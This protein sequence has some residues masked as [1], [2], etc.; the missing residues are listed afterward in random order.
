MRIGTIVC[1]IFSVICM[2]AL[3]AY[4]FPPEGV[5]VGGMGLR[6]PSPAEVLRRGQPGTA[7]ADTVPEDTLTT[8]ELMQMRLDAL[9]AEKE[10]EF[11]TYCETNPA[12]I[13]MPE[14]NTAYLDP[15]FEALEAAGRRTMR[16]LHY[17][18]SQ[19]EGDRITSILREAFQEK[20][21]GNGVGLVPAV[22][23]VP[24]YTLSQSVQPEDLPR[25]LVYGP[26][27]MR[28]DG[29]KDY[30]VMG[31]VAT[32]QDSATFNFSTRSRDIYP[33]ASRFSRVSLLAGDT[34]EA[35][36]TAG[37]DTIYLKENKL[38]DR[39]YLYTCPLGAMHRTACLS[40]HGQAD[41]YGLMLD[42]QNGVAFDNIPMR[43]CSGTIF[44]SVSSSTLAP[45]YSH[46]NVRLIILQY[47]GN[48]VP[49]LKTE[50]NIKH[51]ADELARQV[52]YLKN[53]AP[54]ACFLFIGPSDMSTSIDGTMQT[55]PMLPRVV[56]CL[57]EM[58]GA[59]GIA[60]WDLYAAMGGRGSMLKWVDSDLAG[61][62]YV[63]FTPK[64]ARHVGRV[65]YETLEFYHKFYR[66]RTGKDVVKI[67]EEKDSADT[68]A[69]MDTTATTAA[70][71]DT[72]R[73]S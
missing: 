67:E 46:E 29:T 71:P 23:T 2:L 26:K 35:F 32:I 62:D 4:F 13:Y 21:G 51:Y 5:T 53:L 48:S 64:G 61:P 69:H 17:G 7:L 15:L 14:G 27:D 41:I 24:T 65:L 8:E 47:G 72:P 34:V 44:T 6:F 25:H 68:A 58:A 52:N 28:L 38:S 66:F 31:Q 43:G 60:Y 54:E 49:Y 10:S 18:D 36:I 20:F 1:F 40:V 45:F 57:K 39:L 33:K 3:V 56:E 55:Y 16:I 37:K 19:L 11:K 70:K 9:K 30:G 73:K 59:C 50:E 63:H 12:R 22:Q 42:G